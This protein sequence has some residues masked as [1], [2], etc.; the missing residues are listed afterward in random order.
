VD[1]VWFSRRQGSAN[2]TANGPGRS[3]PH[4][5]REH[6]RLRILATRASASIKYGPPAEATSP[7]WTRRNQASYSLGGTVSRPFAAEECHPV[8]IS[9]RRRP[10]RAVSSIGRKLPDGFL[11]TRALTRRHPKLHL[12]ARDM[13]RSNTWL[14]KSRPSGE[15]PLPTPAG[16]PSLL[17]S[18]PSLAN[19]RA[20]ASLAQLRPR[21]CVVTR[22]LADCIISRI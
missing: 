21:R 12:S 4:S 22:A 11:L 14:P 7:R 3:E 15:P 13:K 20:G 9:G 6:A 10:S 8:D 5:W 2:Q 16:A 19:G 1:E 18:P 17:A